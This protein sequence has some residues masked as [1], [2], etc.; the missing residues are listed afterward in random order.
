M[1]E[2]LML[3]CA[4]EAAAKR[5]DTAGFSDTADVMRAG[6]YDSSHAVQDALAGIKEYASRVDPIR[7]QMLE[8]L[9]TVGKALINVSGTALVTDRDARVVQSMVRA[10]LLAAKKETE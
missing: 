5:R 6:F 7:E 8:A 9:E 3:E 2:K 1:D 10:A 4:R